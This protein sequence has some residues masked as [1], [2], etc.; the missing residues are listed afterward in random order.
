[1]AERSGEYGIVI[2]DCGSKCQQT[3]PQHGAM[4]NAYHCAKCTLYVPSATLS[5]FF[6]QEF[7]TGF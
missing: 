2:M 3:S 5:T 1:M 4:R 7:V 6:N